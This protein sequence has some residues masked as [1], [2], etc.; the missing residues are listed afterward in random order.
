MEIM[1]TNPMTDPAG[2]PA[3]GPKTDRTSGP[4]IGPQTGPVGALDAR[5]IPADWAEPLSLPESCVEDPAP[6]VVA[7]AGAGC[8]PAIYDAMVSAWPFEPSQ[9]P[10]P[11]W[12]TLDWF[13]GEGAFDPVSIADR[14]AALIAQRAGPTILA[15]HSLGAFLSL[16]VALRLDGLAGLI[17][18]NTGARTVGHGDPDLPNR[19]LHQWSAPAQ[20]AFLAGCFDQPPADPLATHLANYLAAVP[21]QRLHAAVA[22]LRQMDIL[23]A[24]PRLKLPVLV[25]HG[26]R[27]RKRSVATARE[28]AQ[29]LPQ[30]RLV[31]LSAGHT[32]MVECTRAYHEAVCEFLSRRFARG[33]PGPAT[34]QP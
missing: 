24:L 17:L 34:V 6:L 30:A 20:Q 7:L 19:I 33:A 31:L 11:R 15:G 23:E 32:P 22:G 29:A 13:K 4:Q 16:L 28:M 2:P 12:V 27:D 21:N 1:V 25:A 26:E 5:H 8:S 3:T 14:I 10:Q 9:G 18:S